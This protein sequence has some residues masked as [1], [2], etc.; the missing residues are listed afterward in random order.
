MITLPN[1]SI[2]DFFKMFNPSTQYQIKDTKN[3]DMHPCYGSNLTYPKFQEDLEDYKS[4]LVN[5]G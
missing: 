5:F 3:L 2:I 1:I 4:N